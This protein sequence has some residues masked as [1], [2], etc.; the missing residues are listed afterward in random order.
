MAEFVRAQIFGTTFEITSRYL[1]PPLPH[2]RTIRGN[3]AINVDAET[4]TPTCNLW[5]WELLGL[6]GI[7]HSIQSSSL[8][9]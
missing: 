6:F 4:G 7:L 8:H 3:R 5:E 1:N 9:F 2:S